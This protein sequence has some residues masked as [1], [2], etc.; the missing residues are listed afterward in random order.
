MKKSKSVSTKKV[1]KEAKPVPTWETAILDAE[2][3]INRL[4]RSIEM[5]KFNQK[6][7][8]GFPTATHN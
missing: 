5:F 2:S 3:E 4:R 7:G 1:N 8:V 6:T